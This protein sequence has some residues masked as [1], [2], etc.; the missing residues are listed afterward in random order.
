MAQWLKAFTALP[1]NLGWFP[2]PT[3]HGLQPPIIPVLRDPM[4][5]GL[6]RHL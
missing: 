5:S 4:L 1:E 2:E 6:N 3:L